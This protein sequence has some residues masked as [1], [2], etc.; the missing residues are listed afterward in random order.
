VA[1]AETSVSGWD[2]SVSL[3]SVVADRYVGSSSG[4]VVYDK[5]VLQTDLFIAFQ[6]GIYVD[7]WNSKSLNSDW[8]NYGNEIDWSLGW[9]GLVRGFGL[10]VGVAYFDEPMGF[11]FDKQDSWCSHIKVSRDIGLCTVYGSFEN[12]AVWHNSGTT[13]G[14]VY[15]IG[16]SKNMEVNKLLSIKSS[17]STAYDGGPYGRETGFLLHTGA[18]LDWKVSEKLTLVIPEVKLHVPLT[19]DDARETEA[20]VYAG[21]SYQF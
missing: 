8:E 2:P 11:A 4:G 12:Y 21:F 3:R 13:G 17:A 16:A 1:L 10:D 20:V 7:F 5:P 19:V 14:N 18:E 9:Y 6:N 15:T